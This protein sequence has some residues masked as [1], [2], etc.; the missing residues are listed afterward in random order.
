MVSAS[1]SSREAGGRGGGGS[2]RAW[3]P[4]VGTGPQPALTCVDAGA[5]ARAAAPESD[6][7]YSAAPGWDA[8][9]RLYKAVQLPGGRQGSVQRRAC[10]VPPADGCGVRLDPPHVARST[11]PAR[12]S[13]AQGVLWGMAAVLDSRGPSASPLCHSWGASQPNRAL[14]RVC[15]RHTWRHLSLIPPPGPTTARQQHHCPFLEYISNPYRH[16]S[17]HR[18]GVQHS[19]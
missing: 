4:Y 15:C 18:Q 14:H 2:L 16:N 8:I 3:L 13:G 9:M 1:L 11:L 19:L 5:E 6:R 12:R 10:P 7:Q 17:T